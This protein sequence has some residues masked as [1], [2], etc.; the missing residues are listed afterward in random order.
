MSRD[1]AQQL[2]RGSAL[3]TVLT[4]RFLF[5][6]GLEEMLQGEKTTDRFFFFFLSDESL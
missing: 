3:G 6:L 2:G 4:A 5:L 1:L